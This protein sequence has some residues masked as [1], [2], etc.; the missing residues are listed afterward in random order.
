MIRNTRVQVLLAIMLGLVAAVFVW[1]YSRQ[2]Q[3]E[4]VAAKEQAVKPPIIETTD[5]LVAVQDIPAL[6]A[7]GW[8]ASRRHAS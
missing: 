4:V 5:V 3:A 1:N 6:S 2:M 8:R 7:S